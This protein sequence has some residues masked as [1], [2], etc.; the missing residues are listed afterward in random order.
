MNIHCH[1]PNPKL[2][3][4]N[5][6]INNSFNPNNYTSENI[7]LTNYGSPNSNINLDTDNCNKEDKTKITYQLNS[8]DIISPI[9]SL[10]QN[11]SMLFQ[12]PEIT[13]SKSNT[14]NII[15]KSNSSNFSRKKKSCMSDKREVIKNNINKKNELL[16]KI[17]YI[18]N[19]IDKT[20]NL[21]KDK[22][23]NKNQN[24][25][26]GYTRKNRYL[27]RNFLKNFPLNFK[28]NNSKILESMKKE[29]EKQ[30]ELINM[31]IRNLSQVVNDPAN[32]YKKMDNETR[33][34]KSN[35]AKLNKQKRFYVDNNI[36]LKMNENNNKNITYV[37]DS[38]L[39]ENESIRK[40]NYQ[41]IKN[42]KRNIYQRD[43]TNKNKNIRDG[44]FSEKNMNKYNKNISE[45]M[46]SMRNNKNNNCNDNYNNHYYKEVIHKNSENCDDN[47]ECYEEMS[48]EENIDNNNYE[49]QENENYQGNY[50]N[51]NGNENNNYFDNF[52]N[53]IPANN[54]NEENLSN[55]DTQIK[56]LNEEINTNKVNYVL[57]ENRYK[58]LLEE[59]ESL[60]KELD[61]CCQEKSN[62]ESHISDLEQKL[63][64]CC[65]KNHELECANNDLISQLKS[66]EN[67][68]NEHNLMRKENE[69]II[70]DNKRMNE[71]LNKREKE[72]QNLLNV[73][74]EKKNNFDA[75]LQK[76]NNL[77]EKYNN[78]NREN[79][80]IKNE[81]FDL[82]K[83]YDILKK[84]LDEAE[85]QKKNICNDLNNNINKMNELNDA[86]SDIKN[87]YDKME[88]NVF[89]LEKQN[90][91]LRRLNEDKDITINDL[92]KKNDIYKRKIDNLNNK[93]NI[94]NS[95][96]NESIKKYNDLN[97]LY[98]ETT[99][100]DIIP[101]IDSKILLGVYSALEKTFIS[102]EEYV[103]TWSSY[104][105]LWQI[106]PQFIFTKLGDDMEKW[107]QI[108]D[109]L[110]KGRKTFDN[111]KNEKVFGA[112][113]VDYSSV[114][115]KVNNK[116]DYWHKEIMNQFAQRTNEG[117]IE[118][119]KKIKAAKD[120]LEKNSLESES[121][122]I[123]AFI[124][125]ISKVNKNLN[126]WQIQKT[127]R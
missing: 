73:N 26:N 40:N 22:N 52:N 113:V 81:L 74:E 34:R 27:N 61:I 35:Y 84:N 108:M 16:D 126:K 36:N 59:N 122:D 41:L 50:D 115:D 104:Q 68:E 48:N 125:E 1:S 97:S 101:K 3:S 17:R 86:Y 51:N 49:E 70:I 121:G 7:C 72:Y 47:N 5:F 91:Q 43:V 112:L 100:R 31:K 9:K 69:D 102:C 63:D 37:Y 118:F 80:Q 6:R 15:P 33:R 28:Y 4:N 117:M 54:V 87:R 10:R 88:K 110:R 38:N 24:K 76:H 124:T 12:S 85:F 99:F 77:L 66:Y 44:Y 93:I 71:E 23:I 53:N 116:Y 90:E 111:D 13:F 14:N 18:S 19:R 8:K 55:R 57:L 114:Q 109:G 82:G 11:Q 46:Y 92:V 60:K 107:Q 56:S 42:M 103:K 94:L 65:Q 127:Q 30:K 58:E 83:K 29:N 98:K 120:I 89:N 39:N 20:I 106:E 105:V 45:Y 78:I 96:K 64:C 79:G 119:S 95:E 62:C 2:L 75:L 21:Y 32:L 25:Y 67:M 123:V